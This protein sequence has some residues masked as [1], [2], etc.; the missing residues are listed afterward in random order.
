MKI[1][2]KER[3]L[4]EDIVSTSPS[5]SIEDDDLS[6]FIAVGWIDATSTDEIA[7]RQIL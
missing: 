5:A 4:K 6:I 7:K 1:E 3:I 2:E